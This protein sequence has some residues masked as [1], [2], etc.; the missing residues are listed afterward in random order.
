[1]PN[2][3]L[4]ISWPVP[5]MLGPALLRAACRVRSQHASRCLNETCQPASTPCRPKDQPCPPWLYQHRAGLLVALAVKRLYVASGDLSWMHT[6]HFCLLLPR[7]GC[8]HKQARPGVRPVLSSTGTVPSPLCIWEP[9]LPFPAPCFLHRDW[10]LCRGTE[11][12]GFAPM[13]PVEVLGE[14]VS[15]QLVRREG[16]DPRLPCPKICRVR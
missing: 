1:M 2:L 14:S 6:V 13:L 10:D 12:F 11:T 16:Q 5:P 4:L 7:A 3:D 8:L 9:S 15:T